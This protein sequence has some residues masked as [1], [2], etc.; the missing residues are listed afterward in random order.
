MKQHK[1]VFSSLPHSGLKL[2]KIHASHNS[3][4]I[5]ILRPNMA[6]IGKVIML[7]VCLSVCNISA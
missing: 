3:L 1:L 6:S 5:R 7:I 2:E 4:P